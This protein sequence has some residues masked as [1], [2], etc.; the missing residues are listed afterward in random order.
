MLISMIR[1]YLSNVA[2]APSLWGPTSLDD[3]FSYIMV[4]LPSEAKQNGVRIRWWQPKHSGTGLSDW[5]LENIVVG[6]RESNPHAMRD[7]FDGATSASGFNWLQAD[8]ID[9]GTYC[10]LRNV[11]KG[12]SGSSENATLMTTDMSIEEGFI[13]QFSLAVGCNTSWDADI[14]PIHLQYSTDYGMSWTHLVREC[15]PF[16]PECNGEASTPSI[17]YRNQAW[18][19]VTIA[20]VG[21]VVSR[22][23]YTV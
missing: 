2:L 22:Y 9:I 15:L 23:K 7:S 1:S 21:P 11:R 19:R 4:E 20:L 14:A 18:Q 6:G 17:Y 3:L 10:G 5:A 8:N 12:Q 13:I 16:I